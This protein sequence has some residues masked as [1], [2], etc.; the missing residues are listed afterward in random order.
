M[1]DIFRAHRQYLPR[2]EIGQKIYPFHQIDGAVRLPHRP[3]TF[4]SYLKA[5]RQEALSWWYVANGYTEIIT[6]TEATEK[7]IQNKNLIL[8]VTQNDNKL[9]EEKIKKTCVN[10]DNDWYI[11]INNKIIAAGNYSVKFIYPEK[12]NNDS[13]SRLI[14]FSTGTDSDHAILSEA[15]I[16]FSVFSA[17]PDYMVFDEQV[18][19]HGFAG[20]KA[21]GY[22]N[23]DWDY[24]KEISY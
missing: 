16:P 14:L 1:Q 17:L 23:F 13:D 19:D 21:A 6:D 4:N 9:I 3:E 18:R 2:C 7:R 8:I 11:K 10:I 22:F 20:V 24:D 5:A 15:F 12:I